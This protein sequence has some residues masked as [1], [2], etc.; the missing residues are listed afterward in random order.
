MT[1][2]TTPNAAQSH[3][4]DANARRKAY[5]DAIAAAKTEAAHQV[6]A[7]AGNAHD[8]H[9]AAKAAASA[10]LDAV[11]K[12]TAA[13]RSLQ[14]DPP[15]FDR[16]GSTPIPI[17]RP[18]VE[19]VEFDEALTA[20]A[21]AE[22]A[23]RQADSRARQAFLRLESRQLQVSAEEFR[24]ALT[25]ARDQAH[26]DFVQHQTAAAVAALHL[27]AYA[28]AL[29]E[30]MTFMPGN[31]GSTLKPLDDLVHRVDEGVA[32]GKARRARVEAEQNEAIK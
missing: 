26:A 12:A 31:T 18:G 28:A 23:K 29:G 7:F 11:G 3:Q 20:L 24:A 2:T 22:Q 19:P 21:A 5:R 32:Y 10:A 4:A 9:E 1:D 17:R 8:D 30:D 13:V 14:A 15:E 6:D 25:K 16:T 27:A